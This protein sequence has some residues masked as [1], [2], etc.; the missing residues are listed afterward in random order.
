MSKIYAHK[1]LS[2]QNYGHLKI[3]KESFI[4]G[5]YRRY[6]ECQCVCGTICVLRGDALINNTN[7]N[8]GCKTRELQSAKKILPNGTANISRVYRQYK[9]R[10]IESGKGFSLTREEFEFLIFSNCAYCDSPPSNCWKVESEFSSV[11]LFY[12]GIDRVDNLI[13]YHKENC[14]AC[15]IICNVAKSDMSLENFFKW[16][17]AIFDFSIKNN[18]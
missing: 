13:G 9:K 18:L 3:I 10:G 1:D 14:V 8:C 2:G 11:A 17:A 6:W 16:V 15:C 5:N 12:N 7:V 4:D